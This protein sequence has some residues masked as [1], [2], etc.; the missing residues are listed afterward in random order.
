MSL[1]GILDFNN[2]A[3]ESKSI[4][5]YNLRLDGHIYDAQG[6]S[7]TYLIGTLSLTGAY[8]NDSFSSSYN[9]LAYTKFAYMVNLQLKAFTHSI[10]NSGGV[11]TFSTL[12][13]SIRPLTTQRY[14]VIGENN[15]TTTPCTLEIASSG[16]MTLYYSSNPDVFSAGNAGLPVATSVTYT[17][18]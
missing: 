13:E 18:N 7:G 17:I 8:S 6:N 11:F 10:T 9:N 14:L 12:P 3:Y 15:G 5:C 2:T 4:R 16:V 1:S